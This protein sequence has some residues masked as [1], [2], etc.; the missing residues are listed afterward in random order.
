MGLH[1]YR[2]VK[3]IVIYLCFLKT[4]HHCSSLFVRN[5]KRTQKMNCKFITNSLNAML[6]SNYN[7]IKFLIKFPLL[8]RIIPSIYKKYILVTGNFLKK[9]KNSWNRI[10][11]RHQTLN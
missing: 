8:K 3:Y 10:Y 9:K 2:I 11:I 5:S 6:I 1:S 7:M 4:V